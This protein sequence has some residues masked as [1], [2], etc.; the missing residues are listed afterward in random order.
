MDRFLGVGRPVA[1]GVTKLD[2][3]P[4]DHSSPDSR[5][6]HRSRIEKEKI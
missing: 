1:K 2:T 3:T 6:T 4:L 5:P